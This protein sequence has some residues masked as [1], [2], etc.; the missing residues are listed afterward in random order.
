MRNPE[1]VSDERAAAELSALEPIFHTPASRPLR[2]SVDALLAESFFEV[3]ASG[4]LY[5]RA[6]VIQALEQRLDRGI[7][8][9]L[10]ALDVRCV[11]LAEACFLFTYRLAEADRKT[12]RSSIWRRDA[13]RWR[14]VYHQGTVE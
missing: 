10:T 8:A 2:G 11:R 3:G 13:G 6:D 7:F 9:E 12:R 1:S 5:S 4:R 14:I